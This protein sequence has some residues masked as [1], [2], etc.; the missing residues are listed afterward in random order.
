MDAICTGAATL[1]EARE[2]KHI[3]VKTLMNHGFELKKW[4]S[5]T[6]GLLEGIQGENCAS[7]TLTF[8]DEGTVIRVLGLN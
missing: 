3:L 6:S 5:S 4:S 1:E 7:R 2:L 8:D